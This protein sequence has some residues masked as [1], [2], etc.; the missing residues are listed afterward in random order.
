MGEKMATAST[1]VRPDRNSL[2]KA[3]FIVGLIALI[4]SFVPI[5]GFVSWLLAPLAIIFGLIAVFRPS[6]SLAIAGIITGI[7][8][9]FICFS[10]IN[11]SKS[12]GEAMS[13]DTFN[14]TGEAVDLSTAPII[15]ATI[16]GVWK[17]IEDNKIAAGEKYG[18]HRLQFADE[19]IDDFAGTTE[20]PSISVIG[21]N[22]EYLSHLVNVSFSQAD[23]KKLSTYKKGAKVSFVCQTIKENIGDGYSLSNCALK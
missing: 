19:T 4:M 22:E 8:A 12:V 3:S 18:K 17:D 23:G 7:I 14:K 1:D 11:A 15:D 20:A 10:W 6:K 21:K 2:G 13:S 16:K 9:L 5:I